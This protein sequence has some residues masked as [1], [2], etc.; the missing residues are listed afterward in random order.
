[1][2]ELDAAK[3]RQQQISRLHSSSS[4]RPQACNSC[5]G[6]GRKRWAKAGTKPKR[7]PSLTQIAD[8]EERSRAEEREGS[9]RQRG[10]EM[11]NARPV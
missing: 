1:M 3:Q 4:D 10:G 11:G 2:L 9:R 8:R 5:S 6:T 7:S